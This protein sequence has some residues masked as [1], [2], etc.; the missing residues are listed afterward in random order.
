M[1]FLV[2]RKSISVPE[3]ALHCDIH[4]KRMNTKMAHERISIN[5]TQLHLPCYMYVCMKYDC[6]CGMWVVCKFT[7]I[8]SHTHTNYVEVSTLS[9]HILRC[10]RRHSTFFS[11]LV[12]VRKS[13]ST[14][15]SLAHTCYLMRCLL[16][17]SLLLDA[18][19]SCSVSAV[20]FI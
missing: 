1:V 9:S 4:V 14:K 7:I 6:V 10:R 5:L 2:S 19:V 8:H 18:T 16:V 13:Y 17:C 20:K 3:K 12:F 11:L 15:I